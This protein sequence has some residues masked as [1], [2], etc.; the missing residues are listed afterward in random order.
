MLQSLIP[1]IDLQFTQFTEK[2]GLA[3]HITERTESGTK[4]YPAI[5]V[6][7]GELKQIDLDQLISYHRLRGQKQVD[8]TDDNT[9]GCTNGVVV[10]Y[11]MY[12]IGALKNDCQYSN[13]SITNDIANILYQIFFTR[14]IKRSIKAW[15]VELRVNEINQSA[16]DVFEQEYTNIDLNIDHSYAYFSISYD[17]IVSAD[18]SCLSSTCEP[19][20]PCVGVYGTVI[21][22]NTDGDELGTTRVNTCETEEI[23]AP[24]ST[25]I[26]QNSQGTTIITE[27]IPSGVTE[28]ILIKNSDGTPF[29]NYEVTDGEV[30]IINN[31]MVSEEGITIISESGSILITE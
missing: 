12:F 24:D 23:I 5:R 6:G 16:E 27:A 31:S 11:P 2:L 22:L 18:S 3:E 15:S 17:I 1:Y 28:T 8:F 30:T 26:L 14:V 4:R 20:Q 10:T 21:L 29:E 19:V 9:I 7:G 13:D 25:A